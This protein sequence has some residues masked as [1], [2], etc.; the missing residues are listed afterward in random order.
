MNKLTRLLALLF[1]FS[2]V[3]LIA[4]CGKDN[5]DETGGEDPGPV[6]ED[7]F[8]AKVD[9]VEWT[10]PS[11]QQ[12]TV[13]LLEA[14]DLMFKQLDFFGQPSNGLQISIRVVDY[15]NGDIGECITERA[16]YGT[17]HSNAANNYMETFGNVVYTNHCSFVV[18][19]QP[20][21]QDGTVTIT[22]CADG[23]VSGTFEFVIKDIQGNV[24]HEVTEGV[25][26][27]INYTF[28]Q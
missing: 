18:T 28:I 25:F 16:Y 13:N 5:D 15:E 8:T 4:S 6:V 3:L 27:N 10:A 14:P 26:T 7:L 24:V 2:G 1:L 23:K 12:P 17:Q 21:S 22:D 9:G 19:S 20:F 11:I